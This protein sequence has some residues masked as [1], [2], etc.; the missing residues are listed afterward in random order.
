MKTIVVE[1][2][3]KQKEREAQGIED[4]KAIEYNDVFADLANEDFANKNIRV[5][6]M[7]GVTHGDDTKDG[8]QSNVSK[9]GGTEGNEEMD[10][11]DNFNKFALLELEDQ[12]KAI[13]VKQREQLEEL[14]RKKALEEKAAEAKKGK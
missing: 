8:R 3:K 5:R 2:L 4:D 9:G 10:G 14:K 11:H 13:K 12:R 6:P 7:S 1:E